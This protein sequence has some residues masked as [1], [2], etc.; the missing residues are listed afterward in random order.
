ML[1][2]IDSIENKKSR[3]RTAI[4]ISFVVL[5]LILLWLFLAS[6]T[7]MDPP[8]IDEETEDVEM[9][10]PVELLQTDSGT[11]S[12]GNDAAGPTSNQ[13]SSAAAAPTD[14]APEVHTDPTSADKVPS[15][16]TSN[17]NKGDADQVNEKPTG[18]FTFGQN[19]SGGNGDGTNNG[20]GDGDLSGLGNDGTGGKVGN[21][22]G[23]R[24]ILKKAPPF[25]YNGEPGKL[26]IMLYVDKNGKVLT[27]GKY[28]PHIVTAKSNIRDNRTVNQAIKAAIKV[29]FSSIAKDQ[30]E[31]Y[32]YEFDLVYKP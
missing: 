8:F 17:S 3:N 12:G 19:G 32:E 27:G 20:D 1:R 14:P 31:K 6:F 15:G 29:E 23:T 9:E 22:S 7:I 28:A 21:M 13:E 11:N 18:K 26:V 30:V 24:K 4:Y 10:V 25:N 2:E 5:C 16:K